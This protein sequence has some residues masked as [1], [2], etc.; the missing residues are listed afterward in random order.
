MGFGDGILEEILE[1]CFWAV[2]EWRSGVGGGEENDE[3]HFCW[4]CWRGGLGEISG[5]VLGGGLGLTGRRE[6]VWGEEGR[7]AVE[8]FRAREISS[9]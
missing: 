1:A 5:G 4:Q 2:W 8:N 9:T 3:S 6:T 7:E